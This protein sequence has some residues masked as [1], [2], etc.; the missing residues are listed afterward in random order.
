MSDDKKLVRFDWFVKFM[1]RDKSNFEILEGFLSE[2][3]KENI[4]I[5]EILDAESNKNSKKG[6]I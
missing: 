2:L 4:R 3:L 6:Q 5:I 1:L